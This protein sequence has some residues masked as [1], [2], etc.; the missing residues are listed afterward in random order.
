MPARVGLDSTPLGCSAPTFCSIGPGKPNSAATIAAWSAPLRNQTH[1][2]QHGRHTDTQG[3]DTLCSVEPFLLIRA[4]ATR[5]SSRASRVLINRVSSC[6]SVHK[7]FTNNE[8]TAASS[9]S[10]SATATP[11]WAP[12]THRT[13]VLARKE[14]M[15]CLWDPEGN[16]VP[17]TVLH[18]SCVPSHSRVAV[19]ATAGARALWLGGCLAFP[20]FASPTRPQPAIARPLNM[21]EADGGLV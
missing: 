4:S 8:L 13:G 1:P 11:T 16:R 12:G 10:A 15:T 20:R 7:R 2:P 14:G 6:P 19:V 21:R 17:V 18:V 9:C 3:L 5:G